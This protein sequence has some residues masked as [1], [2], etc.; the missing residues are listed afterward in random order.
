MFFSVAEN[1][2]THRAFHTNQPISVS[3]LLFCNKSVL[4]FFVTIES[5]I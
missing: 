3:V 5:N 2:T 1:D 4:L